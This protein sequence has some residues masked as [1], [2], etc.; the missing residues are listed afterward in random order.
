MSKVNVQN[1]RIEVG[2][3]YV[4]ALIILE[5]ERI[6]F[7]YPEY[8]QNKRSDGRNVTIRPSIRLFC[9]FTLLM[10]LGYLTHSCVP[11]EKYGEENALQIYMDKEPDTLSGRSISNRQIDIL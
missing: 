6:R 2:N 11:R 7:V 8:A 4:T 10:Y 3:V 1:K 5:T 9:A